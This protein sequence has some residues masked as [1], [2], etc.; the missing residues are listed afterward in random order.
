MVSFCR[1]TFE[2]SLTEDFKTLQHQKDIP[3]ISLSA[4]TSCGLTLYA[5]CC[6]YVLKS[7]RVTRSA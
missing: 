4:L 7:V 1:W 6:R 2:E 3:S 5:L